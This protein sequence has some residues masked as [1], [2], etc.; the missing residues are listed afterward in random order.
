MGQTLSHA[1]YTRSSSHTKSDGKKSQRK[2]RGNGGAETAEPTERKKH[3]ETDRR[4]GN[5]SNTSHS[6]GQC[7][8]HKS[9]PRAQGV[10]YACAYARLQQ[11]Q[12]PH[13]LQNFH[14][15]PPHFHTI[16]A[17]S[18][19][20]LG[21]HGALP[22]EHDGQF[23]S[24]ICQTPTSLEPLLLWFTACALPL[25]SCDTMHSQHDCDQ[26]LYS[27]H[28]AAM[29]WYAVAVPHGHV[30]QSLDGQLPPHVF[31]GDVALA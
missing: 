10:T 2:R 6:A 19:L 11:P 29:F 26:S 4:T 5:R 22:L 27:E 9:H 25:L 12:P 30:L 17:Q 14:V 18:A 28:I 3:R 31:S 7:D 21:S 16:C 15:P 20:V 23:V 8:G 24:L 1:R 13:V